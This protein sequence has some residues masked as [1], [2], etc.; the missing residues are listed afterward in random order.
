MRAVGV[1][2]GAKGFAWISG[3][4]ILLVV[5]A[6]MQGDKLQHTARRVHGIESEATK[7][8]HALHTTR[9]AH[10]QARLLL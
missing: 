3:I 1:A 6:L 10:A 4:R 2:G 5:Q 9:A 7:G 8:S